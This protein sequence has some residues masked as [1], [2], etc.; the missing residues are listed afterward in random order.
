MSKR[1]KGL[2]LQQVITVANV[3]QFC[4]FRGLLDSSRMTAMRESEL[5]L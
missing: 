4:P 2:K 3:F 5:Q 1:E